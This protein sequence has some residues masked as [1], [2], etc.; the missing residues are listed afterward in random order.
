MPMYLKFVD[1]SNDFPLRKKT[2]SF[3]VVNNTRDEKL[4]HIK[5]NPQWRKY[6]YYDEYQCIYCQM[7]LSEIV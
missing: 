4:G 2:K 7:C 6:C 1:V 5:W 3:D